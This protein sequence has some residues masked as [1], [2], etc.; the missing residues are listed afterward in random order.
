LTLE[1]N[2]D[3]LYQIDRVYVPGFEAGARWNDARF[4]IVW[5][6]LPSVMHPRDAAYSD[7]TVE[8]V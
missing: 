6:A 5:P 4:G 3:V 8:A 7:Y 2:S 1:D